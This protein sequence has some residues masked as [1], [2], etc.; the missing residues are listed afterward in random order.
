[1][2]LLA[3]ILLTLAFILFSTQLALVANIGQQAGRESRNP[4]LEDFLQIRQGLKIVL[5][6]ELRNAQGA[7]V[8]PSDATDFRGRV[9][10]FLSMIASHEQ[11]RGQGFR[12]NV[13]SVVIDTASSPKTVTVKVTL[14]LTDGLVTIQDS[15]RYRIE[16]T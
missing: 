3:G 4:V 8:C 9:D 10:S 14:S 5:S 1:M 6:D 15:P 12:G 13:S 11:N 7:V 16:C 2:I